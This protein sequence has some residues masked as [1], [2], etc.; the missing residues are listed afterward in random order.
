MSQKACPYF[1]N[2][3]CVS[4]IL[5]KPTDY[6][7]NKARCLGNYTTCNYYPMN[8]NTSSD[9]K[10]LMKFV[11]KE[12]EKEVNY[13][14]AVNLLDSPIESGCEFF[15]LVRTSKGL[16]ARCV[17]QNRIITKSQALLCSKYHNTCPFYLMF[18]PPTPP[19]NSQTEQPSQT[20]SEKSQK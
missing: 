7:T 13:Y 8:N 18:K 14:P 6:V 15:Y 1:K 4:P 10:G 20:V 5:G 17:I 11:E 19:S 16:V 2:G 12:I 9:N 3:V